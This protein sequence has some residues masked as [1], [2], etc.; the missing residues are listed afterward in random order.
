[1]FIVCGIILL[2]NKEMKNK[3]DGS[4]SKSFLLGY[5]YYYPQHINRNVIHS[6]LIV[7]RSPLKPSI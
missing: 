2:A 6:A 3:I 1:M 5:Y 4:N 7:C